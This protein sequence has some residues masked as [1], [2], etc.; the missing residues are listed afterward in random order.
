MNQF[1][2]GI[3]ICFSL[4]WCKFLGKIIGGIMNIR[5]FAYGNRMV[6]NLKARPHWRMPVKR[7]A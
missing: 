2:G 3:G 5:N 6:S 7:R 4:S 1:V